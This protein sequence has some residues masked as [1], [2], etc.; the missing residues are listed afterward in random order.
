MILLLVPVQAV[1]DR[2]RVL[3]MME[4][5]ATTATATKNGSIRSAST[6]RHDEAR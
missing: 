6:L 4:M 3:I 5:A 2:Y 1:V